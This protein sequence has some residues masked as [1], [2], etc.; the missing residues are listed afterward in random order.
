LPHDDCVQQSEEGFMDSSPAGVLGS[1]TS[2]LSFPRAIVA[3]GRATVAE[4]DVAGRRVKRPNTSG[5][6]RRDAAVAE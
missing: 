3:R 1:P 4:V 5:S 6:Q 2:A